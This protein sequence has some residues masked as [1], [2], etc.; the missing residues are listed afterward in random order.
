MALLA[1]LKSDLTDPQE[2]RDI[3]LADLVHPGAEVGSCAPVDDG[4][5]SLL[6]AHWMM[7]QPLECA[8]TGIR[9]VDALEEEFAERYEREMGALEQPAG[10]APS[11]QRS[12]SKGFTPAARGTL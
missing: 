10:A 5:A 3:T 11:R 7:E 8:L 9:G 1:A 4:D 12:V 6:P 2:L